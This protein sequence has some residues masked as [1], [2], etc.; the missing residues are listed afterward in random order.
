MRSK[1]GHRFEQRQIDL[2]HRRAARNHRPRLGSTRLTATAPCA[3]SLLSAYLGWS[4]QKRSH[5]RYSAAHSSGWTGGAVDALFGVGGGTA[6]GASVW[7]RG[8]GGLSL[9]LG[10]GCAAAGLGACGAV[11]DRLEPRECAIDGS[12][13]PTSARAALPIADRATNTASPARSLAIASEDI[14]AKKSATL[15]IVFFIRVPP[16]SCTNSL[17]NSRGLLRWS[18]TTRRGPNDDTGNTVD[19]IEI[20]RT[21]V[22]DR[23]SE[24]PL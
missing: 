1:L 22:R 5:S 23:A 4:R 12:A 7:L 14:S 9:I 15:T 21:S 20:P 2:R 11:L 16:L 18:G 3:P 24:E 6:V 13:V 10:L 17:G 8:A 19:K